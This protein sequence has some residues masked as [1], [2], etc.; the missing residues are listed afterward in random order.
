MT[1]DAILFDL[2]GTLADTLPVCVGACQ[3]AY[4]HLHG[5][6][7]SAAQVLACFGPSDRGTLELLLP[8]Q[9]AQVYPYYLEQYERLHA[10][11]PQPF[12]GIE[13]MFALLHARGLRTAIVTA[14][15]PE[16]A[17]IS[18]RILGLTRW[19]EIV[20]PGFPAGADKPRA[21]G[22]ALRRLG[23]SA[24]QAAYIGDTPYDMTAAQAAGT[25]PLGAAWAETSPLRAKAQENGQ[26]VFYAVD[27]FI[28]WVE[29]S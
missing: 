22:S 16:T 4:Q 24:G 13:R 2:D 6:I 29:E 19:V 25:L 14:K 5:R 27:H 3:A 11:V 26:A 9:S 12:P 10:Q 15:G 1:L 17:A 28:R 7:P 18:M 20:E 8:G 21:I 23:L